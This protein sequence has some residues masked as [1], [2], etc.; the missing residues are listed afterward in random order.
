MTVRHYLLI[1][2][3]VLLNLLRHVHDLLLD[4]QVLAQ[5][6]RG[7]EDDDNDVRADDNDRQSH[8]ET[9][10]NNQVANIRQG[11]NEYTGVNDLFSLFFFSFFFFAF[12]FFF[13]FLNFFLPRRSPTSNRPVAPVQ[14]CS[15]DCRQPQLCYPTNRIR[16]K[17]TP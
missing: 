17:L 7:V 13:L 11:L 15:S 16:R 12:V 4:P 1:P 3:R 2:I 14:G 8:T 10:D 9:V 5:S 6:K